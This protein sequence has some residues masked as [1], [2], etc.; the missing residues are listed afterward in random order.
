[1]LDKRT[2]A[3]LGMGLALLLAGGC[4]SQGPTD[5]SDTEE[6]VASQAANGTQENAENPTPADIPAK[7]PAAKPKDQALLRQVLQKMS[8]HR[9]TLYWKE[10]DSYTF[11]VGGELEAEFFPGKLLTL[12]DLSQGDSA[13]ALS[14]KYALDGTLLEPAGS[15]ACTQLLKA[16][17]QLLS[18]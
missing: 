3:Y 2:T 6:T 14:C 15:P 18:E 11:T 13:E 8:Q 5:T 4:A 7:P 1:M 17:D 16:L 12:R 10:R 9:L